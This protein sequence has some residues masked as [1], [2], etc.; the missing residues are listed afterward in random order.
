MA[1]QMARPTKH[2]KSGTYRV[3]VTT[4]PH[5]KDAAKKLFGAGTESLGTKDAREAACRG[6]AALVRL[7]AGR[8]P[9]GG[10]GAVVKSLAEATAESLA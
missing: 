2:P 3:R 4:P 1:V 9:G 5:L 10:V 7:T 6:P 8:V